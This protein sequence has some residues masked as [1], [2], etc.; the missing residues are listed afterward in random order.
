MIKIKPPTHKIDGVAVF[1][2]Q[3]D[4]AWDHE[5]IAR[6]RAELPAGSVH[7]YDDYQRG[8]TRFDLS[9]VQLYLRPGAVPVV[10]HLRRL[11]FDEWLSIQQL[12]VVDATVAAYRA[13]QLGVMKIEGI[14]DL[15]IRLEGADLDPPRLTVADVNALDGPLRE[16]LLTVGHAVVKLSRGLTEGER[17]PSGS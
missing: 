5:R 1:V 3:H 6:E 7:P 8:E 9:Q 11:G 16:Y 4:S 2:S 17:R 13:L 12:L 10:W 14:E 15:G